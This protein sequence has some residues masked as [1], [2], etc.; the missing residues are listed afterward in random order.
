MSRA[1]QKGIALVMTLILIF[2]LSVMSISL[3]FISQTETWSSLNYRLT[4]Q[5][6]DGAEAGINSA[7]NYIVNSYTEPGGPGDPISAYTTNVSPVTYSGS[8]VILSANT[9]QASNYPVS[10]VQN[11]FNTSGVG[12]GSLTA[13]NVTVNYNTYAKLLS[14]HTAFKPLGST[15]NT[16]VQTW[17]IV[18]DGTISTIRNAK[19]EV[20]AILEQHIIPTF[21]YAVFATA[22]GCSAL[23]F[24]GGGN[25]NSYDSSTYSGIGTPTFSATM[26]DVGTNGNLSTNGSPT[27]INGDLFTPRTG[28]GTCTSNNVTAWTAGTG[29]VTGSI[30]ELPQSVVYPPP[31]VPIAPGTTDMTLKNKASDCAG[32]TGC[33][34][35]LPSC[36]AGD[37]CLAPGPCPL[38]SSVTGNGFYGKVTAK[39]TVHLS[40]GCYDIDTL[41]ENGG[42]SIVIDSG[43][44]IV[45]IAALDSSGNPMTGTVVDLTGGSVSNP[46]LV[47]MN[48]QLLYGGSGTIA[49]RGGSAASGTLYAPNATY[50]F[51]GGGDWYGAIVGQTMT[52][53][54]GAAVHYDR[55]LQN[56]A[57]TLGPWMLDSFTWKKD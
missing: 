8:P 12:S 54:G 4:S 13:G 31:D 35:D 24:G 27:T 32:V 6:R 48:F 22:N 49:L 11:A 52:D 10:S 7:A 42:G 18:S 39:G 44:A 37:F 43:P 56:K 51:T 45:N 19:V 25:T 21:N 36:A 2:V 1:N 50:S 14:M 16:T 17:Q 33:F 47:P 57:Y 20:S 53:M 5:A 30:V 15:T 46:G 9:N 29:H 3:M 26:G 41:A 55:K 38:P 28:V 34:Y 40:A 23:Q